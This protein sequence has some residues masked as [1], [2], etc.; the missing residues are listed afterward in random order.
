[1]YCSKCNNEIKFGEKFCS[2]CESEISDNGLNP[3]N[4]N[5]NCNNKSKSNWK[6]ITSLVIGII[7][8]ITVFIFQI[9]TMPFSLI[10][11][12][13]GVLS[14]KN[15]KKHKAGLILNIISFVIAIP[16]FMLYSNIL[17]SMPSNPLIGTWNCKN[18]DGSGEGDSYVV[19]VKLNN[20]N[21]FLWEKYGETANNYVIGTYEFT[22]LHKTNN[23]GNGHYYSVILNGDEYVNDGILQNEVYK[24]TYEVA[25]DEEGTAL[26]MNVTTYNM[27]AC[28][29]SDKENPTIEKT[30]S[31]NY[32][33]KEENNIRIKR[34][35]YTLPSGL[36]E[37]SLNTDTYKSYTYMN[38]NSFCK[39]KVNVYDLYDS[40]S[41]QDY[42]EEYVNDESKDLSNLYTKN[43]NG[44][45]WT[46]LDVTG[47]YSNNKY[48]V[49][50]DDNNAYGIDF[51]ITEDYNNEC[52]QLYNNIL[53]NM[54]IK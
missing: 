9:F 49:Y 26:F 1:M 27:Y 35:T 46:M 50:I 41:I 40:L 18:F 47:E 14:F 12:V 43:I 16:I 52:E 7:S 48:G 6:N 8:L 53:K 28:Y 42:F 11:I 33:K 30:D 20:D 21:N 19:T 3:Q 51:S 34:L 32:N 24:S 25:V 17:E 22:D 45:E 39:F 38:S 54:T 29:R 15:N 5:N 2:R 44:V 10:G 4:I 13:F 23:S 36:T 37:G 31:N